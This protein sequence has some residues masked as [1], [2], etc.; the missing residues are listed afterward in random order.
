[1]PVSVFTGGSHQRDIV[2]GVTVLPSTHAWLDPTS[3]VCAAALVPA[4]DSLGDPE[5]GGSSKQLCCV[6][7]TIPYLKI[8]GPDL[9]PSRTF[10]FCVFLFGIL[11]A[12]RT[13]LPRQPG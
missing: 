4:S 1:M 13:L 9:G 10:L 6:L 3:R 12:A 7:A 11:L 5:L 8:A 2:A